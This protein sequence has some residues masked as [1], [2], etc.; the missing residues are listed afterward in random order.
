MNLTR[1]QVL[2]EFIDA[3]NAG[4]RPDVDDYIPRVAAEERDALGEELLAFVTLAP[5][6]D[7]SE[8]AMAAIRAEVATAASDQRGLFPALLARVRERLSKSTADVAGELVNELGLTKQQASKTA[9]Y[10]ERLESG[11]L[12]PARVSRRVF[13]ALGKVLGVRSA[14]LDGAADR[15]GW[16]G[17]HA[18]PAAVPVFRADEAAAERAAR[19]LDVLADALGAPGTAARD[20]VDELFL[21]GR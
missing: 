6:P 17:L 14:E 16:I 5:T 12:E 13:E 2:S 1:E 15:S 19:H 11:S 20:E 3:W 9:G 18:T 4:Q 8:E 21:G 10:L 7:Y